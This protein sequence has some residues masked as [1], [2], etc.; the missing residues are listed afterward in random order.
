[1]IVLNIVIFLPLITGL[2][3]LVLPRSNAALIR[4]VALGGAALTLLGTL[5]LWLGYDIPT[6]GLQARTTLPWIPAIGASYDVAVDGLSLPLIV[7]T[8]LLTT[9]VM[10]YVL[11]ERERVKEHAFLFLLMATGLMGVFAAQ[12]LLLFYLFFEIGLVPMYF[13]IGIWGGE[14][15]SIRGDQI[16][17]VHAGRQPGD[18]AE[19]SGACTWPCNRTPFRC[20]RLP[21]RSQSPPEPSQARWCCSAWCSASA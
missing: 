5:V 9:L 19:L 4:W 1:M 15:R 14:R 16:L 21:P 11:P 13:I 20:R 18:A 7:L 17:F 6:G 10:V 12:D 8:A 3:A 2:V